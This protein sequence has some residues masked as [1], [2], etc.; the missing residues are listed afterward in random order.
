MEKK[1][2]QMKRDTTI[3]MLRG[4]SILMIMLTHA[5][6]YFLAD[7]VARFLWNA[8]QFSVA[9]FI[10]CSF[11][12]FFKKSPVDTVP[13]LKK[14]FV[15]L[16]IPY[17][18]FLVFFI[19]LQFLSERNSMTTV[20]VLHYFTLSTAGNDLSWLVLLFL[21]LTI[22]G[23][24]IKKI[25]NKKLFFYSLFALSFLSTLAFHFKFQFLNFKFIMWLPWSL[26]IFFTYY[27]SRHEVKKEFLLKVMIAS[28]VLFSVL[29][30][31]Q[32]GFLHHPN[33]YDNKYPPNLYHLLYGI[34]WT[35]LLIFLEKHGFFNLSFI[36]RVLNF[37]SRNSY[38]IYFIH[39]LILYT[40]VQLAPN[41]LVTLR[42]W[43]FLGVLLLGSIAVQWLIRKT[44]AV[45]FP[46]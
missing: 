26:I 8:S 20:D 1:P 13:Y 19:P 43:G 38:S 11:Y 31:L 29:Y 30:L 7:S 15:R 41:I 33:L 37:L 22:V 39:F 44:K 46:H 9:V 34:F 25:E 45:V 32:I 6:S 36:T 28:G 10:F 2:I 24:T 16:F 23:V 4:F 27:L 5:T 14:R 21:Q 35:C 12:L 18:V 42:W 3:D 40:I 17:A